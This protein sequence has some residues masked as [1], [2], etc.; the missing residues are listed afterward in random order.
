MMREREREKKRYEVVQKIMGKFTCKIKIANFFKII[1]IY[2][3][4]YI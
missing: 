3:Y 1:Y 2:I 4:I